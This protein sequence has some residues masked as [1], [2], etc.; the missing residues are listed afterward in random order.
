M[1]ITVYKVEGLM[2]NKYIIK[3]QQK[4][5]EYIMNQKLNTIKIGDTT[6]EIRIETERR[7]TFDGYSTVNTVIAIL[8]G[9]FRETIQIGEISEIEGVKFHFVKEETIEVYGQLLTSWV[10]VLKINDFEF[11]YRKEDFK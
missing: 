8:Y 7:A 9:N 1:Q 3:Q 4:I 11:T 6:F 2:Y 10:A 5:G